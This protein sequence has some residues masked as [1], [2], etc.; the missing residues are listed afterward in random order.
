MIGALYNGIS[1]LNSSQNALNTESNNIANVN[2]LGYKSDNISFADQMY[3]SKIGKGVQ[4]SSIDKD[5]SQ[6]SLQTSNGTYDMAI[7]GKGFFL[8]RGD[9]EEMLY[10][11]AGNFRV[12]GNGTLQTPNGFQVQGISSLATGILATGPDT[13]FTNEYSRFIASQSVKKDNDNYIETINVKS[14]DYNASARSDLETQ[15]GNNFKTRSAKIVDVEALATAYRNQ[16]D[17][18]IAN[19][20]DGIAATKQTSNIKY[21]LTKLQDVLDSVEVTVG[22]QTFKQPFITDGVTTLKKLADKI[23]NAETLKASVDNNGNLR[24]E[25]MIPGKTV[26]V[27]GA[28]IKNGAVSL[29]PLPTIT[30]QKAIEGS[31]KAKLEAIESELKS[32]IENAGGKYLRLSN[33]I[34][35]RDLEN[36]T[37]N[38]LQIQL[39]LLN[40]SDTPF[41]TPEL[42]NGIIYIRQGD[43]R[44][45]IGKIITAL[46]TNELGLEPKGD[47]LYAA[48]VN[49][50]NITFAKNE[51]KILGQTLEL[52]NSE[53]G[54]SLVDLIVFQR[55]F[56][57]SSKAV[58]TSDEFLKTAI[59]LKR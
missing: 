38:Q 39:D 23:S 17:L 33:V 28:R 11:R 47:N 53:I 58:T 29:A 27:S 18:Y 45:A 57:A 40:I 49:S 32:A 55:S 26:N 20:I 42:D 13:K 35:S 25:Q 31:G 34:D 56:E 22:V 21:D 59:Q 54:E 16:L 37:I 41:G 7:Q 43:N 46:F 19:S 12:A 51:N 14:T 1:G 5:F 2:T 50:G 48:T 10:T 24:I 3:Q 36:T 6:G 15:S 52:S 44:F 9:T 8:V 4:V 30:T